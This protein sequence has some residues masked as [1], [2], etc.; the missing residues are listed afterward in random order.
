MAAPL[1]AAGIM[2]GASLLGAGI[3]SYSQSK[4]AE[5]E[6]EDRQA[7][8]A[9]LLQQ[10]QLTQAEY[11]AIV[12]Q[13]NQYYNSRQSLGSAG[14]INKY[15]EAIANYNPED[16]VADVGDFNDVYSKNKEDFIN[17]YYSRIIGDTAN[18]I[19]HSAAG[20]GLG[21]GTGAALNIAKGTAEKSDEL[22]RT[23][24]Q[25]YTQDRNFAYQQFTD[26][27]KNN[28]ARLN[29]L[30]SGTEYKMGLQGNL[31]QDYINTQDARQ[32]DLLK[33]QQD[34]LASKQAYDT[35][36]VGLY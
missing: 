9:Q 6:R 8:A 13:I 29:A 7:A 31:A 26:A 28:Q 34:R 14:D 32:S 4:A 23:A 27:I 2:A 33:A 5:K 11:N 21:R 12:G 20:A 1:I 35:A 22:Y 10:G 18:T 36:I 25:D 3:Q 16:Y 30:R 19:Q 24:M 15:R 17:P